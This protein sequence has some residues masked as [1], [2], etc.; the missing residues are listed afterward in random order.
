MNAFQNFEPPLESTSESSSCDSAAVLIDW[1]NVN[2][3]TCEL[4]G[5][6]L[7]EIRHEVSISLMR[8]YADWGQHQAGKSLL[9]EHGCELVQMPGNA[10]KKNSADI[11]LAVDAVEILYV[12]PQI[13]TLVLLSGDRD[14]LPLV[15]LAKRLDRKVWCFG[16]KDSTSEILKRVCNRWSQ[17]PSTPESPSIRAVEE[18]LPAVTPELK[19]SV[20]LAFQLAWKRIAAFKNISGQP[21][22][23][24]PLF[25]SCLRKIDTSF[26]TAKF[27]GRTK[28]TH[29]LSAKRLAD[30]GSIKI[31]N[32]VETNPSILPTMETLDLIECQ[33]QTDDDLF[34]LRF[35]FN[36]IHHAK[37]ARQSSLDN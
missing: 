9:A 23:S 5:N 14:F 4:F 32:L 24:M 35:R 22:V 19:M 20:A 31:D 21:P 36:A 30:A 18:Y 29:A 34:P 7:S 17:I 10:F 16:P 8:A 2:R 15:Q 1:E 27:C 28:R 6:I 33:S 12:C 13:R 26:Q 3:I 25:F 11:K 37:V